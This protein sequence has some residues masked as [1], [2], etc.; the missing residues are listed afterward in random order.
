VGVDCSVNPTVWPIEWIGLDVGGGGC[1]SGNP[2][3]FGPVAV[4]SKSWSKVKSLYR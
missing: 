2:L 3:C 1:D 4:E